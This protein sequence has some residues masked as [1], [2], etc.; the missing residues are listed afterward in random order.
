VGLL[1]LS[2]IFLRKNSVVVPKK[3]SKELLKFYGHG[4][5]KILWNHKADLLRIA[6]VNSFS[7]LTYVIPFVTMNH[8]IPLI[9][10]IELKT[11]MAINSF[12]L[13]FDMVA[14]PSIGRII[15]RFNPRD[16]M[17]ISSITLA[18]TIIPM[19]Y[20]IADASLAYITFVR[21]WIVIWGIVFCAP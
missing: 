8:L 12:M 5:I 7:H 14:I 19:W 20:F 4:G 3:H 2:A 6:I 18:L 15:N 9:T 11:M 21:F 17:I 1:Q 16:I 10:D 13:V